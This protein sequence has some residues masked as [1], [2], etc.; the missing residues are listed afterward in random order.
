MRQ[1]HQP[2][3]ALKSDGRL[4][5]ACWENDLAYFLVPVI[6]GLAQ[7]C[8]GSCVRVRLLMGKACGPVQTM[9]V[10]SGQLTLLRQPFTISVLPIPSTHALS[11]SGP[12]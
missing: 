9:N 12:P 11:G 1:N 3:H 8:H 2:E 5:R 4:L 6:A 10:L 7:S